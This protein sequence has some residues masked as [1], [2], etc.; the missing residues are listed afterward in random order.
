MSEKGAQKLAKYNAY[1]AKLTLATIKV[2]ATGLVTS[3]V[4]SVA[5]SIDGHARGNAVVG[6]LLDAKDVLAA[7]LNATMSG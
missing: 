7:K 3:A 1:L 4:E 2:N 6:K 5:T